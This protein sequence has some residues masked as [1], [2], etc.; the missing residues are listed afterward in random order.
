MMRRRLKY[1][2]ASVLQQL[3]ARRGPSKGRCLSDGGGRT[4]GMKAFQLGD[5]LV[6]IASRHR[7]TL[8]QIKDQ[9]WA[10]SR[11][12]DES[13]RG[14]AVQTWRA[15]GLCDTIH[16]ASSRIASIP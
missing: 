2:D 5:Q 3:V 13:G 15:A 10:M 4:I 9:K 12:Y 16:C 11:D 1:V 6:V 7:M 8:R 14:L